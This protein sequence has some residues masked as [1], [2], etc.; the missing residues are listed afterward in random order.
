MKRNLIILLDTVQALALSVWLGGAAIFWLALAPLASGSAG[1]DAGAFHTLLAAA[2][3]RVGSVIQIC[4]IAIV[5]V[6]F[7]LRRRYQ[8]DRTRFLVDGIRQACTLG[9][10]FIEE[11]P[12]YVHTANG[13]MMSAGI[14]STL[15]GLGA[16]QVVL[17]AI[18]VGLTTWLQL[19]APVAYAQPAQQQPKPPDPKRQPQPARP[20]KAGRGKR[21]R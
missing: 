17:L 16:A 12:R 8:R 2:Q 1:A 5:G 7:V 13:T 6:Q 18:V 10:L 15:I 14:N 20:A 21:A 3:L 19:S 11:F 4:G 9:A